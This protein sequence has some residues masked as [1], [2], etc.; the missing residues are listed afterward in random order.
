MVHKKDSVSALDSFFDLA[1]I[2]YRKSSVPKFIFLLSRFPSYRGSVLPRFYCITCLSV[3]VCV[4]DACGYPGAWACACE[5]TGVALLTQHAMRMRH[6]VSSFLAPIS[7]PHFST[8]THKRHDFREKV[9]EH[10]T[11]FYFIYNFCLKHISF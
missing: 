6:I 10:K 4:R 7:P 1:S 8:L 5:R 9:I 2:L 3:C 11:C